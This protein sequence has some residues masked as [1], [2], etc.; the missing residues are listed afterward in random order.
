VSIR[1]KIAMIACALPLFMS[2]AFGQVPSDYYVSAIGLSGDDLRNALHEII[3]DHTIHSYGSAHEYVDLLDEDPNNPD[4]VLLIYSQSSVPKT[5]WGE[6]NREHIWP[7]S[8]G[9]MQR[10]A[11]SDMHH[12][13]AVDKNVNSSRGNK[14]FDNCLTNCK[15]HSE[16]ENAKYDDDSWEP[17]DNVKGDIARA[18]FY[19]DVRYEG[20]NEE[21][22]LVLTN[23]ITSGGCNCM[24]RLET[25]L[26]W[27]EFDPVDDRERARNNLIFSQI[28][29]NR[30]P[31][32]D[33]PEWVR[34]IWG[35]VPNLSAVSGDQEILNIASFNVQFLGH[36]RNR[37]DQALA[38]ILNDFDIV[39]IQELV[40]P[41]YEGFFP[42]GTPFNPDAEAAEFFDAMIDQGFDY[43]LSD[44]DTGPTSSIH[45]N[46]TSTEWWVVFYDPDQVAS[47]TDIPNGFL[48]QDRSEN[49]DFE[50]VPFAFAFRTTSELIDFV[51]I[52]VHLEPG[53]SALNTE[54]RRH[55]LQSIHDWIQAQNSSEHDYIILGDMNI[56]NHTEL[57]AAT[58]QGFISLNS[59]CVATNTN[60]NGPKP[61][62]HVML[63]PN[64]TAELDEDFGLAVINLIDAM[65][66]FWTDSAPYPGDIYDHDGFRQVYSDHNPIVFRLITP[67]QDDD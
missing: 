58:P 18:L 49:P 17:P 66:P 37:D 55:E 56:Q 15:S 1:F 46:N 22:D 50:R 35:G 12:I 67:M 47:I 54:R 30:N 8:L 65:R 28:Q 3:D 7:A 24:G 27:H 33:H 61:Y 64:Y 14:Y 59:E 36:F 39:V 60:I 40:A 52:S 44:E 19:M 20:T 23:D 21:P 10:P 57:V 53:T 41:P 45:K 63:A 51:L 31:F 25:L 5:T 29:G 42:D 32:I 26:D 2:F 43:V 62:D 16:A 13:F 34:A 9:T 48:A 4:N 6:Y 11:K 38:S